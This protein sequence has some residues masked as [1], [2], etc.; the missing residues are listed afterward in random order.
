MNETKQKGLLTELHCQVAFSQL[1]ILL[2]APICQDS[3]YDFIADIQ[4]QLIKIQCKTCS[5][6]QQE[7]GI[8]FATRSTRVNTHDSYQR[9]YTKEQIDYFYTYYDGKSYLV[10]VEETSSQ[11]TLRFWSEYTNQPNISWA[12]DYELQEVLKKDFN[13]NSIKI[14]PNIKSKNK[15]KTLVE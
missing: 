5:V 4:G 9:Y 6:L 13:F 1:G 8:V 14:Q 2:S 10:K 12:K 15:E 11:K 7:Q 3:R